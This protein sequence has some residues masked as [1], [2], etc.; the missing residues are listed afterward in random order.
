MSTNFYWTHS[1]P[2]LEPVTYANGYVATP[3][4]EED[5]PG[6]HIGKRLAV[7]R[8]TWAQWPD[9]VREVC[10]ARP[11]EVCVRDEYGRIYTGR[12][13]LSQVGACPEQ[14]ARWVGKVFS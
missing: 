5:D 2:P 9:D 10:E 1:G 8:F 11:D 12:E 13:F 7:G 3:F 4:I 14:D 6:I